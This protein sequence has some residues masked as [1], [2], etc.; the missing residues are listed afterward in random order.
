MKTQSLQCMVL[1]FITLF[2]FCGNKKNGYRFSQI[3]SKSV[4]NF[5]P[6]FN[7]Y[8]NIDLKTNFELNAVQCSFYGDYQNAID[9]ATKNNAISN[10]HSR[11]INHGPGDIDKPE[12]LKTLMAVINDPNTAEE[13]KASAQMMVDFISVPPAGELF[14]GAKPVPAMNYIVKKAKEYHFTLIN[15]AHYNSQHRSFNKDL[16]RPL[17]KEGYRYLALEALQYKDTGLTK[18]GYPLLSTGYYIKDSNFGNLVREALQ[19]GYEL[20]PYETQNNHDG[21]L[22]DRDQATNIYKQTWEKDK[23]GKVLIH[24]GYSHIAERGDTGYEPMGYQLKKLVNQDILTIDQVTMV[25]FND[26]AELHDYYQEA[27]KN[28]ELAEPTIFLNK[29]G[30]TIVDPVNSPAIDIQVYHPVTRFEQ[31]RPHWMKKKGI[32]QIPLPG[33]LLKYEGC[34]ILAVI[35]GEEKEAVPVD[36]FVISKEKAFLLQSGNYEIRIINCKGELVGTCGLEVG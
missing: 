33:S 27:A 25:G 14:A 15:E 24:A 6:G 23:K 17:W 12:L 3:K 34:L 32:K 11:N 28:F 19:M 8:C 20:V 16:L 2:F 36:Q 30:T 5:S 35:K 31:G 21:T 26:T 22:R 29:K 4:S 1:L 13:D 9:Q 7:E 18:R 10:Q